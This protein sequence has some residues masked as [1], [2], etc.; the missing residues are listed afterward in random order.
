LNAAAVD[1]QLALGCAKTLLIVEDDV[2]ARYAVCDALRYGG[3]TVVEASSADEAIAV[4]TSVT[5]D[6]IFLDLNIPNEG[7]GLT[8]ARFAKD[9]CPRVKVIF[10]SGRPPQNASA[11]LQGL[12]PF[13]RKPYLISKVLQLIRKS[14]ADRQNG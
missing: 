5:V 3:Y 9:H 6:L 1:D 4:L 12:G 7:E 11:L 2:L 8:V 13:V 14:L 10:T